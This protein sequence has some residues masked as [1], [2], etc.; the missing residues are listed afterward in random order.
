ML[1]PGGRDTAGRD[2]RRSYNCAQAS[3]RLKPLLRRCWSG[4]EYRSADDHRHRFG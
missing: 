3:A 1:P 2:F 4:L